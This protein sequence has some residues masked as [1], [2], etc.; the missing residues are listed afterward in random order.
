MS[1]GPAKEEFETQIIKDF[2]MTK[3]LLLSLLSNLDLTILNINFPHIIT[4]LYYYKFDNLS[5]L[6]EKCLF[7]MYDKKIYSYPEIEQ[8]NDPNLRNYL[9]SDC[10]IETCFSCIDV[11]NTT[12][13]QLDDIMNIPHYYCLK[14]VI[15][16]ISN[17]KILN[18]LLFKS[19]QKK[20]SNLN[21]VKI[22]LEK[23]ININI[24]DEGKN[25]PISYCCLYGHVDIFKILI[26][27]CEIDPTYN[28]KEFMFAAACA[29]GHVK[30]LEMLFETYKDF[31]SKNKKASFHHACKKGRVEVVKFLLEKD[32]KIDVKLYGG[33][34]YF[35]IAFANNGMEI[36]KLLG[37]HTERTRENINLLEDEMRSKKEIYKT[38]AKKVRFS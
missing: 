30:I 28:D 16:K 24:R 14:Y 33:I 32:A 8:I 15:S 19:C 17:V 6:K 11:L 9:K 34:D 5:E 29:N 22:L 23:G 38:R 18:D 12:K 25:Q 2:D 27:R 37:E 20:T 26:N 7:R 3:T 4:K 1:E 10:C 36:I 31:D 35:Q 21:V 13:K